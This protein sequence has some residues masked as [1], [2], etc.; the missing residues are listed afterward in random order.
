MGNDQRENLGAY[1]SSAELD[2][3][4]RAALSEVLRELM[5]NGASRGHAVAA[6]RRVITHDARKL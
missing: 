1:R 5:A 3:A 2:A 4:V 6:L